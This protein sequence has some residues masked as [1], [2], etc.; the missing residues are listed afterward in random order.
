MSLTLFAT[1]I[2][3]IKKKPCEKMRLWLVPI[4]DIIRRILSSSTLLIRICLTTKL[5]M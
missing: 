4:F 2:F 5:D 1:Q 3:D